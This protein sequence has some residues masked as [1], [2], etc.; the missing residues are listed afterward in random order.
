MNLKPYSWKDK[1]ALIEKLFPVQ[2]LSVESFK[3]QMA[4]AG[5][6]VLA[7]AAEHASSRECAMISQKW[8]SLRPE[9]LWRLFS[10]TVAEAGKEK[11]G[12]RGWKKALYFALSDGE[13][14][15]LAPKAKVKRKKKDV[16]PEVSLFSFMDLGET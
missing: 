7:W 8:T 4:G 10:K 6:T 16:E 2:K 12:Q 1:P 14:I 3:E 15:R 9:E 13:G 5:K 11:D